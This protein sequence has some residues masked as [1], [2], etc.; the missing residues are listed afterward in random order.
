[1]AD[2]ERIATV[3]II[4]MQLEDSDVPGAREQRDALI[5]AFNAKDVL[6][7]DLHVY[8][9]LGSVGKTVADYVRRMNNYP[10]LTEKYH[11]PRLGNVPRRKKKD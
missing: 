2:A 6:A 8:M 10:E 1:M 11:A 5:A 4:V 9:W 3:L 7:V